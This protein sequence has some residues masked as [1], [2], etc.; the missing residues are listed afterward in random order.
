MPRDPVTGCPALDREQGGYLTPGLHFVHGE[1]GTGKTA[2]T[3]QVAATRGTP[4]VFVICA[5][6]TARAPPRRRA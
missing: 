5:I 1:P 6:A 4:A 3:L 2:N